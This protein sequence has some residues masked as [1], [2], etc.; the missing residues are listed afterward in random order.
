MKDST[1]KKL[2]YALILYLVGM[3]YFL[4]ILWTI[5]TQITIFHNCTNVTAINHGIIM[6][7]NPATWT[8]KQI[9]EY[10]NTSCSI[11]SNNLRFPHVP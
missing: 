9:F 11:Q 5:D 4:G 1:R 7:L 8:N 6:A 3:L 10:V 2:K